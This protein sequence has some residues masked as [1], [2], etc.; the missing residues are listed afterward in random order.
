MSSLLG[1]LIEAP[2]VPG[3]LTTKIAGFR[4]LCREA[5]G[6]GSLGVGIGDAS[7]AAGAV[8]ASRLIASLGRRRRDAPGLG[9]AGVMGRHAA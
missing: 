4:A 7:A 2:G 3:G 8:L 1:F 9:M 6:L 5:K